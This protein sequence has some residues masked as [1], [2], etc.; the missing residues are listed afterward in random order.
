MAGWFT[1]RMATSSDP[2]PST[3]AAVK[4]SGLRTVS[5]TA[6]EMVMKSGLF[7]R[8]SLEEEG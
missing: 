7:R 3:A 1:T 2:V 8:G 6:Q 5:R 4:K